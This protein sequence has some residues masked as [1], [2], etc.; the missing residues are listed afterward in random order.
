MSD[1]ERFKKAI[2]NIKNNYMQIER[3]KVNQLY[4]EQDLH[5]TTIGTAREEIWGEIFE[6]LIP[7]KFVVER[8][9]FLIDAKGNV[10]MEADLVIMDEMYT[11]YIFR[12]GSIKFIPIE[13]VAAVIQCKST[14]VD[15]KSLGEW[16]ESIK[17]L[18][19]SERA[20]AR[21]ANMFST[22][23]VLT[24]PSTRPILILCALKTEISNELEKL[25]DIVLLAVKKGKKGK[26]GKSDIKDSYIDV[27]FN[28]K[29]DNLLKWFEAL[30]FNNIDKTEDVWKRISNADTAKER[31]GGMKLEE[32]QVNDKN[33]KNI[34]LLSFNLQFNQLLMLINNPMLFPH[35]DYAKL[36]QKCE[37]E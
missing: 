29:F 6:G 27:R 21:L 35:Q 7:K 8:S 2:K 13:A 26:K 34:S 10:S 28:K 17:K 23:P 1:E 18:R 36:F 32:F 11:P 4:L 12:Y 24:Q 30:N 31:L 9:V 22:G 16:A 19:T 5:P 15:K 25:F 3:S 37:E 14:S 20:V 33:G